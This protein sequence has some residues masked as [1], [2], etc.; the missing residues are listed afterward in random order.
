VA[1]TSPGKGSFVSRFRANWPVTMIGETLMPGA[2]QP[3]IV[4]DGVT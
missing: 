3:S 1:G 4:D 2:M